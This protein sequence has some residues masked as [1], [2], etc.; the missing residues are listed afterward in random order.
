MMTLTGHYFN[1]N[2]PIDIPASMEFIDHGVKF[3]TE[4]TTKQYDIDRLTVSPRIGLTDRFV[5]LPNGGQFLC[6]DS[7]LLDALPQESQ[8]EGIVAWLEERWAIALAC[9]TTVMIILL[10]GYFYGLPAAAKC[11]AL[12]I[13]IETEVV[14][15]KEAVSWLDERKWFNPTE[16]DISKREEIMKGFDLLCQ[17]LPMQSHLQLGFRSSRFLGPNALAFPGGI[18]IITDEMVKAA[19]SLEEI[20]AVLAHEIGHVELRHTMRS[21][22]QGSVIGVTIAAVTADAASLSAAVTGLPVIIAETKYSRDFETEA[23]D[24]AFRLLKYRGYS[25][26]AFAALMERLA[27]TKEESLGPFTWVSTHP[28]TAERVQRARQSATE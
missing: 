19:V 13:P 23:D 5:N 3:I 9:V 18:I 4:S 7:A 26:V 22:L 17:D 6:R 11:I 15:G 1:G 20:L 21:V 24:Y 25:P 28:V 2:W 27:K 8:S 12:K 16:L 10:A 14:L